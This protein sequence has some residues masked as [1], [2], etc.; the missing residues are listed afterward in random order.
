M[1]CDAIFTVVENSIRE[2]LPEIDPQQIT[3][4]ADL[5]DLGADSVD[6]ADIITISMEALDLSIPVSEL[7]GAGKVGTLVN[8]LEKKLAAKSSANRGE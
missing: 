7:A 3:P 6:R 2:V 4:E 8:L 1:T 5:K